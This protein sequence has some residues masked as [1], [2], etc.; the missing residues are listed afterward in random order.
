M[1]VLLLSLAVAS[2]SSSSPTLART[3]PGLA[4]TIPDAAARAAATAVDLSDGLSP[5]EAVTLALAADPQ[6]RLRLW[7][8][9]G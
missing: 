8:T 9:V 4:P 2:V 1:Q 6:Q 7:Q 3:A 5:E